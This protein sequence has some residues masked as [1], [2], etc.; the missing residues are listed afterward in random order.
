MACDTLC[1]SVGYKTVGTFKNNS[2]TQRSYVLSVGGV[3]DVKFIK[4]KEKNDLCP[5]KYRILDM[6][7]DS[8]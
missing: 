4:Y 3:W 6:Y 7:A 2:S 8:V 1:S 5:H